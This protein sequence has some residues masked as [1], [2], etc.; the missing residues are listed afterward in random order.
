MKK[1]IVIIVVGTLVSLFGLSGISV[2]SPGLGMA[3]F[4]VGVFIIIRACIGMSKI[5]KTKETKIIPIPTQKEDHKDVAPII[6]EQQKVD[7]NVPAMIGNLC[8]VYHYSEVPFTPTPKTEAEVEKMQ[9]ENTWELTISLVDDMPHAFHGDMDIGAIN[10]REK[11]I[12]D[13]LRK[14]DLLKVW[15]QSFGSGGN[16]VF[17]GFYRDEQKRLSYRENAV[18]RLTRY[19]NEDAQLAING[20]QDGTKLEFDDDYSYD[21]PEDTVCITYGGCALG[22]L[23]KS[24]ARKYLDESA[25]AVFLDHIDYDS[26]KDKDIPYVKI[27]W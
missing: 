22:A 20:L 11:M 21:L 12:S 25:A 27:Y 18:V 3:F 26:D 7:V 14:G 1:N 4:A 5:H 15:L 8:L 19:A 2:G 10:G 6:R 9:R 16:F 17:L 13:W 24:T 23:P